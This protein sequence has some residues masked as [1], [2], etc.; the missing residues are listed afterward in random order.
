MG[1]W[2]REPAA[3]PCT[4]RGGAPRPGLPPPALPTLLTTTSALLLAL[5]APMALADLARNKGAGAAAPTAHGGYDKNIIR[6]VPA[7]ALG[8]GVGQWAGPGDEVCPQARHKPTSNACHPPPPEPP[9]PPV[10]YLM[11]KRTRL[12]WDPRLEPLAGG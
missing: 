2:G 4:D 3:V 11:P 12:F 10:V 7:V 6:G 9:M 5:L 8:Q 1:C